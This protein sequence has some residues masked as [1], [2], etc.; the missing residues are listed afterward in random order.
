MN[1]GLIT[2]N[3]IIVAIILIV[4]FLS[5]N[6][7][8]KDTVKN[9]NFP[10]FKKTND[11]SSKTSDWLKNSIPSVDDLKDRVSGGLEEKEEM[12][13]DEIVNQKEEIEKKSVGTVK[14]YIAEKFLQ[15]IGVS[16]EDLYQCE[17]QN[18]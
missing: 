2:K 14:K 4:A 1:A 8:F 6:S 10:L 5:Q 17:P 7:I 15:T 18:N 9:S 13:K 12:L 16:P 11:Y 3:I